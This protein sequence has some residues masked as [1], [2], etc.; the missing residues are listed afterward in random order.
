[1]NKEQ[2][3]K[4]LE[5]ACKGYTTYL[6]LNNKPVHCPAQEYVEPKDNMKET[7][8]TLLDN[9]GLKWWKNELQN[10]L[11]YQDTR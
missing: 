11:L 3:N 7:L 4:V 2:I 10:K 8:E 9:L 5:Y 1:M 6:S